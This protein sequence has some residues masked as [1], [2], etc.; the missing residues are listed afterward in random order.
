MSPVHLRNLGVPNSK[1]E[2]CKGLFRSGRPVFGQH[3]EWQ[4]TQ[5]DHDH[6]PIHLPIKQTHQ[7]R[8]M[9]RYGSSTSAPPTPQTPVTMEH[10][11]QE[12]KP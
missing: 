3:D 4:G 7:A 9:D 2:D 11:K 8:G 12:F 5:G 10:G 6:N 1:P